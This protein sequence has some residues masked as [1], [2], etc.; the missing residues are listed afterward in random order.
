MIL[1]A[2]VN[3]YFQRVL[4]GTVWYGYVLL[5]NRDAIYCIYRYGAVYWYGMVS[6]DPAT[7]SS[8][9]SP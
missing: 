9:C 7:R 6:S 5:R 3:S 4:Q 8:T 1:L 2:S